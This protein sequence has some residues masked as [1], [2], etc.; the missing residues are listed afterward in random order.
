[1]EY[2]YVSNK[3]ERFTRIAVENTD[4]HMCLPELVKPCV[5]LVIPFIVVSGELDCCTWAV[6]GSQE[7]SGVSIIGSHDDVTKSNS[8]QIH[9]DGDAYVCDLTNV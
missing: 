9:W 4:V 6:L 2:P 1:M 8:V 7:L 3:Q 5:K